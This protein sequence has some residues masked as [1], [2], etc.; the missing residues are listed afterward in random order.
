[1]RLL[2]ILATCTSALDLYDQT[3]RLANTVSEARDAARRAKEAYKTLRD[4]S[5]EKKEK[6]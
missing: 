1:M 2:R 6:H 5:K 4:A 3:R